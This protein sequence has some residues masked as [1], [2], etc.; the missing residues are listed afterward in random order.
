M[1]SDR[2]ADAM[3]GDTT[4]RSLLA[5]LASLPVLSSA[6]GDA[7]TLNPGRGA[8]ALV[9]YFT[10]SGNTRV[11]AG[12]IHRSLASDLFEIRPVTPYPDDYLQTVE[13]ASQEKKRGYRPPLAATVPDIGKYQTVY[14]GF[15]IWGE[16]APAVIRSFLAVHELSGKTLVPFITHGGFGLGD[17]HDQLRRHAPRARLENGFSLQADQE[18]QTMNSVLAWLKDSKTAGTTQSRPTP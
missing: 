14:L 10:R 8:G 9:A 12:L 16:T 2:I 1:A 6:D 4:R 15:P 11:V 5:A 13:Q 18:R 3:A 7:D 17:S